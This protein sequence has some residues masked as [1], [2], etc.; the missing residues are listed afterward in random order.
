[1]V[2]NPALLNAN[3]ELQRWQGRVASERKLRHTLNDRTVN[4]RR[5]N[6]ERPE[7]KRRR[8][9]VVRIKHLTPSAPAC[10]E[11]AG[12]RKTSRR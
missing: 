9:I 12:R 4:F 5:V 3:S 2:T 11:K 6:F 1:M 7:W 10:D 8:F